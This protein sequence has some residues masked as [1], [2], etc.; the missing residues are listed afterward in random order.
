MVDQ[1]IEEVMNTHEPERGGL[2]FREYIKDKLSFFKKNDI[3][4]VERYVTDIYNEVK[5][6]ILDYNK[7]VE[8]WYMA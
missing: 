5:Y 7:S 1:A 2:I 3:L 8:R 4:N 6:C